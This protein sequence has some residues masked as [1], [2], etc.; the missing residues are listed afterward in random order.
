VAKRLTDDGQG[1][2]SASLI[3]AKRPAQIVYAQILNTGAGEDS[4]PRCFWF[5]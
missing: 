2:A 3:S 4:L 5:L 1:S